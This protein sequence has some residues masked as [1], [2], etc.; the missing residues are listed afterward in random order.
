[1]TDGSLIVYKLIKIFATGVIIA[2][3][4][5][6]LNNWKLFASITGG[7]RRHGLST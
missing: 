6:A 3:L 1:M 2:S 4:N 5:V 7:W